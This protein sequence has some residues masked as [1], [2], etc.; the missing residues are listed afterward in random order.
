MATTL[1]VPELFK[2]A[3]RVDK[4]ISMYEGKEPLT[5]MSGTKVVLAYDDETLKTLKKKKQDDY[6]KLVFKDSKVKSKTYKINSFMKSEEFG[7]KP[8]KGAAG[9][10]AEM[11]TAMNINQQLAEI[12]GKTGKKSVKIKVAQHSYTVTKCVKVEGTPKS[13]L[14]LLDDGGNEVVWL[15]YKMG[16]R[17]KDFQQWSGMTEDVIQN[18][19]EVQTFIQ[20]LQKK[21]GTVMPNA[22]TIAKKIKD[23]KLKKYA[24]YGVNFS[25]ANRNLGRQNVSIVLQGDIKLK[26]DGSLAY[27]MTS[28]HVLENGEA[29]TGDYEPVLMAI[30]KGD[31]S[32]F[33]LKGARFVI[34]PR[35]SRA[36]TEWIE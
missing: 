10:D 7:G 12:M 3:W 35:A 32:Q 36:V 17:A 27:E 5:L 23:A 26:K 13:D 20:Q 29:I 16:T 18:H 22:T 31:R 19:P 11:R 21:F 9:I 1:S 2:Y 6:R 34:Q 28:E 15:S 24:V 30:Y 8:A 4:F 14:A 33:G 25:I